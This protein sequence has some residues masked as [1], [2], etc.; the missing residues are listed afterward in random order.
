MT[1]ALDVA[2]LP[3]GEVAAT[4]LDGVEAGQE[5]VLVGDR[6]KAAKAALS[7]DLELI[8]PEVEREWREATR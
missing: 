3:A 6:T 4:I 7:R 8:Y 2:K 5:E 1:A